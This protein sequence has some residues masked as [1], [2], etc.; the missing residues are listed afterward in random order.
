MRAS[1]LLSLLLLLQVRGRG[2]ASELAGALEV[3]ERTVY[4]DVE[5]LSQAG[6]PI[7]TEQ[8]RKGGITLQEGFR[9]RLTG[10]TRGEAE[11]LPLAGWTAAAE[12]LGFRAEATAAQLK[13]MASLTPE[14]RADAH[15][16][17]ERFHVDPL[18][19]YHRS[20]T[21]SCLPELARAVW[22]DRRVRLRYESWRGEVARELSP[23][24]LVIKGGIWYLVALDDRPKTY[25]VSNIRSIDVLPY[26]FPRPRRF[27][28]ERYWSSC[29]ADFE[30]RLFQD[31]ATLR[32]SEEGLRILR[33]VNPAAAEEADATQ[34]PCGEEGWVEAEIHLEEGVS[35]AR[36]LLR[37]GSEV[38]A[39]APPQLRKAMARE[40]RCVAKRHERRRAAPQGSPA[41]S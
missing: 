40:A 25:R 29:L 3:S 18:P 36:Q 2:T 11:A 21:P 41:S 24:G 31:R 37:L 16:I 9:T 30:R 22:E 19:W 33:A 14:A 26:A 32:I 17:A 1:R 28:L 34:R 8:G 35:A 6:I 4:R 38:E 15:R 13:L 20:D 39:L 23:L 7:Y 12:A 5:A 10:L 27:D